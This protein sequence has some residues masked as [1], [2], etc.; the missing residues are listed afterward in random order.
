MMN[1]EELITRIMD[2]LSCKREIAEFHADSI[3]KLPDDLK[4][5]LFRYLETGVI[6]DI[7]SSGVSLHDIL[8]KG[9]ISIYSAFSYL[10]FFSLKPE[11]AD[12][13]LKTT[14]YIK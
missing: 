10:H 5:Q 14:F 9:N 13:F 1:R 11:M 2:D 12:T 3:E 7:S 4:D 6:P 8:S